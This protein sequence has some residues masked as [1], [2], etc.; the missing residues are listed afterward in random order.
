MDTHQVITDADRGD[1]CRME[2]V[3]GIGWGLLV[4]CITKC[5][6]DICKDSDDRLL[7]SLTNG[8]IVHS[9]RGHTGVVLGGVLNWVVGCVEGSKVGE[10]K[11]KQQGRV[12]GRSK[13]EQTETQ[14][15]RGGT[16]SNLKCV[17]RGWVEMN[18]PEEYQ[19]LSRS[20]SSRMLVEMDQTGR[21]N[22]CVLSQKVFSYS[23]YR[24]VVMC[25]GLW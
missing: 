8:L 20:G 5:S 12:E 7:V 21:G 9:G 4:I 11:C 23:V 15:I 14:V 13:P 10:H 22:G 16:S 25:F 6:Q 2:L 1:F 24:T 17:S 19:T 3:D 18:K